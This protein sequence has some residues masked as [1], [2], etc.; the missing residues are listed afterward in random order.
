MAQEPTPESTPLPEKMRAV[1][2][3]GPFEVAVEDRPV[4]KIQNPTDVVLRV[5]R[6]ALCG[7]DLVRQMGYI[8]RRQANHLGSTTTAAT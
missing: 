2:F 5:T 1:I 3:K 4:P 6:T 7:S 8:P